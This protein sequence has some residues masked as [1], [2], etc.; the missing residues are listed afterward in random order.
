MKFGSSGQGVIPTRLYP[1]T[2]PRQA[3][4]SYMLSACN[5]EPF[6]KNNLLFLQGVNYLIAILAGQSLAK[7]WLCEGGEKLEGTQLHISAFFPVFRSCSL[8]LTNIPL[9]VV[10]PGFGRTSR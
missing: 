4:A 8:E 5:E 7:I 2:H 6:R 9:P 1:F 10:P 3:N